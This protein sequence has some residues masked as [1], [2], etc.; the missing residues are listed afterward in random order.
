MEIVAENTIEKKK[1]ENGGGGEKRAVR[2]SREQVDKS[3]RKDEP[4]CVRKCKENEKQQ[5]RTW[6][7]QK[8]KKSKCQVTMLTK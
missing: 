4:L 1:G 5:R 6:C 3:V 7:F 8:K 2:K